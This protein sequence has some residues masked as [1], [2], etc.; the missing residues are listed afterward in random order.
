MESKSLNELKIYQRACVLRIKIFE[1]TKSFPQE[2][3]FRLSDQIIR[4]TRK[5]PAN[6]AEGYGRF[7]FQENIQF[8]R[9]ARGSLTETMDHLNCANECN[10]I[11]IEQLD[12]YKTEVSTL[13]KMING[14]IRY[15]QSQ[16]QKNQ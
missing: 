16:K 6:I 11:T 15:L 3:R 13:I 12:E 9:I 4:S 1:L 14:Y 7:H 5:C 10:Y 2:E 8:C